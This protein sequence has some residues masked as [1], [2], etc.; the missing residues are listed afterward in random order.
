MLHKS[1]YTLSRK[2]YPEH[3]IAG[4]NFSEINMKILT[5]MFTVVSP[6][7]IIICFHVRNQR[8][9]YLREY[10]EKKHTYMSFTSVCA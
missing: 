6:Y 9:L 5:N 1:F 7:I 8:E 3:K 10:N 2:P 4:S